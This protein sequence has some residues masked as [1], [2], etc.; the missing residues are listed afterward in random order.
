MAEI[1][2][3]ELEGGRSPGSDKPVV[4]KKI[5]PHL[6]DDP[7]FLQ[8]FLDEARIAARLS[9]PSIVQIHDL[10][11]VDDAW[12]IAMEYVPGEDLSQVH[13]EALSRG[14]TVPPTICAEI[15]RQVAG[16]LG[17]AHAERDFSG[18]PLNVVHRDVTPQNVMVTFQGVA[19]LLDFGIA[20]ANDK[21]SRTKPGTVKGKYFY[22]SPE[23]CRG[24]ELDGRS[25]I[26]SLGVLLYELTTGVRPFHKETEF[27][28]LKAIVQE[29]PAPPSTHVPDYPV[30]LGAILARAMAKR[31]EERYAEAGEL[32][33]ELERYLA[34]EM[35][36]DRPGAVVQ[37]M[38]R[39]FPGWVQPDEDSDPGV[40]EGRRDATRTNAQLA[41][42]TPLNPF[43]DPQHTPPP[44]NIAAFADQA[45]ELGGGPPSVVVS[46]SSVG[47]DMPTVLVNGDL[48]LR[49]TVMEIDTETADTADAAAIMR[50]YRAAQD[51]E[52]GER[53]WR[54]PR[55]WTALAVALFTAL[56]VGWAGLALRKHAPVEPVATALPEPPVRRP[57]QEPLRKTRP[58]EREA[59]RPTE[60]KTKEREDAPR[61]R[62]RRDQREGRR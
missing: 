17:Y 38:N 50:S 7:A 30:M 20:K 41:A 60:R 36:E 18:R 4:I 13:K 34:A 52:E 53:A 57:V 58:P 12:Y 55:W 2:L 45:T 47:E 14:S 43:D 6:T 11:R 27:D 62:R 10:G 22:M 15:V 16:A 21:I 25:D 8:M 59:A 48:S 19:K 28:T 9:H 56:A 3:A 35:R 33:A 24:R 26:F 39:L 44:R 31:R 54:W 49:R 29:E 46:M 61:K 1:Y 5:L 51:E 23:Q 40:E 42:D 37:F 32:A